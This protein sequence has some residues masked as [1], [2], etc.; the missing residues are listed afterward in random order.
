[1]LSGARLSGAR[2]PR[3]PDLKKPLTVT[4][5][6]AQQLLDIGPTKFWSLVRVGRIKMADIGDSRMVVYSSLEELAQPAAA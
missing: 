4:P 5:R 6:T 2:R 1:M 3:H